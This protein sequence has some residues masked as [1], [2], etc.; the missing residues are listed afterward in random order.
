MPEGTLDR[1]EDKSPLTDKVS[2]L[3]SPRRRSLSNAE[4]YI[5][6]ERINSLTGDVEVFVQFNN[7]QRESAWLPSREVG[8]ELLNTWISKGDSKRPSV[9]QSP[10][11]PRRVAEGAPVAILETKTE[12]SGA[13][14][15]LVQYK[16]VITPGVQE[17]QDSWVHELRVPTKLKNQWDQKQ[18]FGATATSQVPSP[19]DVTAESVNPLPLGADIFSP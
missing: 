10:K 13:V 11:T 7:L 17:R 18:L 6:A 12:P 19:L 4:A 5:Q 15:Y 14:M 2:E 3:T 9:L 16:T 1:T 8:A